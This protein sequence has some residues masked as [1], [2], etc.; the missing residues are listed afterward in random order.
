MPNDSKE[1]ATYY[2][3]N[4]KIHALKPEKKQRDGWEL[5]Y[6]IL[7]SMLSH[8]ILVSFGDNKISFVIRPYI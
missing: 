6:L 4:H 1:F 8:V 2:N 7:F 3:W 5:D